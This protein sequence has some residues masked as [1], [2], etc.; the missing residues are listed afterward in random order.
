[1]MSAIVDLILSR[2]IAN[3]LLGKKLLGDHPLPIIKP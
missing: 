2:S 3:A 1:M